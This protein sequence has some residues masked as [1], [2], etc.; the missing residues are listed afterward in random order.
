MTLRTASRLALLSFILGFALALSGCDPVIRHKTLTTV[1]DGVPSMPPADQ[2]CRDYHLQ[3]TALEKKQQETAL[4]ASGKPQGGS[5]H[6]PYGEKRCDDCHDKAKGGLKMP[7][8]ELCL[9][10]HTDFNRGVFVHGPSAVGDCL[11]C[12]LPH[13]SSQPTLL[14][15]PRQQVCFICHT[16]PRQA[17]AMHDRFLKTG[18]SCA[19]CHSPHDSDLRYFLY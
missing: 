17:A 18:A 13:S 6:E 9:S 12:H 10:C 3:Q 2:Y 15:A 4:A 1:F 19:D 11:A 7:A 8:R 5:T 14:I 16:E